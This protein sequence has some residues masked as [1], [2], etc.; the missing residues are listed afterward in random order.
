MNTTFG[1][2]KIKSLQPKKSKEPKKSPKPK[3]SPIP[4]RSPWKK[5]PQA[6]SSIRQRLAKFKDGQKSS[7]VETLD[8]RD[9]ETF[10]QSK[11]ST[12]FGGKMTK[13]T[14]RESVGGFAPIKM[15]EYRTAVKKQKIETT[16][17]TQDWSEIENTPTYTE[18]P[19][20][21]DT[22]WLERKDV[23][24]YINC[25]NGIVIIFCIL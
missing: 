12:H 17:K 23:R 14:S 15:K 1:T 22:S 13:L 24:K 19:T 21:F 3:S 25:P 18:I 7:V 10:S 2:S 9:K 5:I 6:I 8:V 4:K 11:I 16:T 20:L